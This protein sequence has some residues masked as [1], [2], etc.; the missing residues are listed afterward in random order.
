MT[1]GI[2]QWLREL[3]S[4]YGGLLL[5]LFST[6]ANISSCWI[7]NGYAS[8]WEIALQNLIP[9]LGSQIN[10]GFNPSIGFHKIHPTL[11]GTPQ[12]RNFHW[13]VFFN[14]DLYHMLSSSLFTNM[15]KSYAIRTTST[16]KT[17]GSTLNISWKRLFPNFE[18]YLAS[19]LGSKWCYWTCALLGNPKK[20]NV[21]S[22]P[23]FNQIDLLLSLQRA[24]FSTRI[25]LFWISISTIYILFSIVL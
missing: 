15:G 7:W 11:D 21:L 2:L 20:K 12:T 14:H 24:S 3:L 1:C 8:F 16:I 9:S 17:L 18:H 19:W 23:H 25:F 13:C 5:P 10:Q 6:L 4:L 22:S